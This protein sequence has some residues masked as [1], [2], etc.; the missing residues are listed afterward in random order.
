ME[1]QGSVQPQKYVKYYIRPQKYGNYQ[2]ASLHELQPDY[3]AP[4]DYDSA[5]FV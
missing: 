2:P 3:Q 1:R 5:D 4:R